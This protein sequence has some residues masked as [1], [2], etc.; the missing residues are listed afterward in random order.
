[1]HWSYLPGAATSTLQQSENGSVGINGKPIESLSR[2]DLREFIEWVHYQAVQNAGTNLGRTANKVRE[3][4][5]AVLTWA[6]E[7]DLIE[8]IPRLPKPRNHRDVAGRHYL[9]KSEIT[10]VLKVS[11]TGDSLISAGE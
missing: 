10:E 2:H 3:N 5:K 6:W 8:S 11:G 1:M 7:Q 4:L 9:T